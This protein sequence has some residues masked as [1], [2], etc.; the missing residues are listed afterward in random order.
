MVPNMT[1]WTDVALGQLLGG[2]SEVLDSP[3]PQNPFP[4][5]PAPQDPAATAPIT[6][7][8]Q[9]TTLDRAKL[10]YMGINPDTA[11]L[12]EI[13]KALQRHQPAAPPPPPPPPPQVTTPA[14]TGA[15]PDMS[16]AAADAAK[17]L[18]QALAKNHSA[19]NDADDQ[20]ADAI[21]QASSSSAE[22]RQRLQSLQQ[23]IINEVNKLGSSLDTASGQQQLAEFLQGKTDDILS[24]LKNAGLDSESH[25][26][27][28]DGLSARYRAFQSKNSGDDPHGKGAPGDTD[29]N[30]DS[31]TAAPADT[32]GTAGDEA[33]SGANDPLLDGLASD[34]LMS[35]LG[36]MAG[37]A[38]GALGS[39]PGA[40]GSAI[41]SLGGGGLGGGGLGDLGSAIGSALHDGRDPAELASDEHADPLKD[42]SGAHTSGDKSPDD[43]P[44]TPLHDPG[45]KPGTPAT[46]AVNAG[47]GG[48]APPPAA[49]AAPGQ[50]PAPS[51]QVQLP[52]QQVRTAA[53][54]ALAQAGRAVLSGDNIDDAYATANLQLP[55][56]GAPVSA[57]LAPSRLQFGDIAQFTDHRVM[58]IDKDHVWLNGQITP[59]DQL[60]TGPNF[61]G[62]TRVSAPAPATVTAAATAPA[63]PPA[64]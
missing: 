3:F 29:A 50:A 61:L 16:G 14:G 42:P 64:T 38:M 51:T 53:T 17:R 49:A 7:R 48:A 22:G 59:I 30:P 58:A 39:L 18:D 27:V 9:L 33:G 4:L 44:P 55:P 15:G 13:N 32:S 20:L 36:M 10:S 34:P 57:P 28:L 31:A 56:L 24:V 25:S 11:P 52:D 21:L 46:E 26:R 63:P 2:V 37:P 8:D 1:G 19:L 5:D 45:N 23:D 47:A 43:S 35:R 6:S 62:W 41:P 60:E 54:P 12:P 40:L